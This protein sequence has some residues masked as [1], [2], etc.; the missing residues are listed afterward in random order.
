MCHPR[1]FMLHFFPKRTAKR[2]DSINTLE[3][4][5]GP[6]VLPSGWLLTMGGH[7]TPP[8]E[9]LTAKTEPWQSWMRWW[10]WFVSICIHVV[11]WGIMKW[12]WPLEN[13]DILYRICSC[14]GLC[15]HVGMWTWPFK[16]EKSRNFTAAMKVPTCFVRPKLK[17]V[18]KDLAGEQKC[19]IFTY[20]YPLVI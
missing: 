8:S 12:T 2:L 15:G 13:Y 14:G 9:T 3:T 1:N 5:F 7:W 16:S 17:Q 6:Q 19:L 4:M 20:I 18:R 10:G 11:M